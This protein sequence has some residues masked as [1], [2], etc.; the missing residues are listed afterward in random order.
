MEKGA[1]KYC[2]FSGKVRGEKCDKEKGN[3]KGIAGVAPGV[4]IVPLKTSTNGESTTKRNAE[5]IYAAVDEFHCD[6]INISSGSL[7]GSETLHN[8]VKYAES[9][10]QPAMLLVCGPEWVWVQL[11]SVAEEGI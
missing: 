11:I 1:Y 2:V 8:A 3:G 5:A 4:T 6:V 9:K 10:V 7:N